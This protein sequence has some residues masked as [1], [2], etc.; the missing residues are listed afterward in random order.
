VL[1][2]PGTRYGVTLS[3]FD[4]PPAAWLMLKR[5]DHGGSAQGHGDGI[6]QYASREASDAVP[7]CAGSEPDGAHRYESDPEQTPRPD[8][9]SDDYAP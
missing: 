3:G 8:N 4:I 5:G 7:V 9:E 6:D 2:R 1:R